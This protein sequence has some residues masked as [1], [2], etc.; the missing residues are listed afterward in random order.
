MLCFRRMRSLQKIVAGHA[1][2][3]EDHEV[4]AVFALLG[5]AGFQAAQI[6]CGAYET[7]PPRLVQRRRQA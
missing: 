1:S 7:Y 5:T 2:V 4:L 6:Y 3:G